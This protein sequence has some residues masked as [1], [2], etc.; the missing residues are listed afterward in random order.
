ML[1]AGAGDGHTDS[2]TVVAFS[3]DGEVLVSGGKDGTTRVWDTARGSS[4]LLEWPEE[5]D[6][7]IVRD[8]AFSPDGKLIASANDDGHVR[9]WDASVQ[10]LVR[11][12]AVTREAG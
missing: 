4:R 7:V 6:P 2:V 11:D 3:P 10:R 1:G 9:V 8:L 5:S 12:F